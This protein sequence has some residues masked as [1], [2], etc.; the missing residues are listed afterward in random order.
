L[1]VHLWK[2][3]DT[4]EGQRLFALIATV[5]YTG[6]RRGEVLGLTVED[7]DID[8]ARLHVV[9]R[10]EP[11]PMP[12]SLLRVLEDWRG[13]AGSHWMFPGNS[14]TAPWTSTQYKRIR[15]I[16]LVQEAATAAG[17]GHVTFES[18]REFWLRNADRL[19]ELDAYLA[20]RLPDDQAGPVVLRSRREPPTVLGL[21]RKKPL[22]FAEYNVVKALL[23]AGRD[24]LTTPE[25]HAASG[26]AQPDKILRKLI[27]KDSEWAKVIQFPGAKGRG[28]IWIGTAG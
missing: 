5:V 22:T 16:K 27:E 15:P 18:L 1:L 7:C 21:P 10:T 3:S 26:H 8:G 17:L 24:G 11:V 13:K 9:G 6:L 12:D 19:D 14:R 23:G 20:G 2:S 28:G 4:W 25:L